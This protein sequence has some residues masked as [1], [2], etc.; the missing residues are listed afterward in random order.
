MISLH[1]NLVEHVN[2]EIVLQTICSVNQAIKWLYSTFLFGNFGLLIFKVRIQQ[3]PDYYQNS[4]ALKGM[5]VEKHLEDLCLQ[6]INFLNQNSLCVLSPLKI[7][8]PTGNYK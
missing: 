8:Q 6:K 5:A 3:N 2:A 7:I 1:E 4:Y